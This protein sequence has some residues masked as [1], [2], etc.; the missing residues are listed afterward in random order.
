MTAADITVDFDFSVVASGQPIAVPLSASAVNS[1]GATVIAV[2][3][4]ALCTVLIALSRSRQIYIT[5]VIAVIASLVLSPFLQ[6]V[7]AAQFENG[8]PP[9]SVQDD[10]A[11]SCNARLKTSCKLSLRPLPARRH[12]T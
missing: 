5:L 4:A 12:W 11:T 1:L 8:S 9:D 10:H 3:F 7:Q 2:T 6:A